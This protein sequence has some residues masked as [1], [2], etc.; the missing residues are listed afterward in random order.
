MFVGD[1]NWVLL[2][3]VATIIKQLNWSIDLTPGP[4]GISQSFLMSVGSNTL[5][6]SMSYALNIYI[7]PW[8]TCNDYDNDFMLGCS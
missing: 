7:N 8:L 6:N 3:T 5:P 4:W 2:G 1:Y